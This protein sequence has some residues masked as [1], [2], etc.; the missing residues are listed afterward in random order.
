MFVGV[1]MGKSPEFDEKYFPHKLVSRKI[2]ENNRKFR[3]ICHKTA[4]PRKNCQVLHLS[5]LF[6]RWCVYL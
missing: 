4:T 2:L 5:L 6:V 3:N 1:T